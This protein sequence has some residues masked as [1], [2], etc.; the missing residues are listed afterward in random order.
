[1]IGREL[2]PRLPLLPFQ[3]KSMLPLF[4]PGDELLVTYFDPPLQ[5]NNLQIG[6]LILFKQEDQWVVHR[7]IRRDQSKGDRSL[8]AENLKL[9]IWGLITG[10]Q[11]KNSVFYWGVDGM[12]FKILLARLSIQSGAS[13]GPL[14]WFWLSLLN[15]TVWISLNFTSAV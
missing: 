9:P 14:R 4:H 3:G 11:R 13:R 8:F 2:N 7:L 5:E 12:K 10:F 6:D 1:M 15:L